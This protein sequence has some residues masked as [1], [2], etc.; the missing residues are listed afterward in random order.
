MVP[1]HDWRLAPNHRNQP[2]LI[3]TFW[4]LTSEKAKANEGVEARDIPSFGR[5]CEDWDFAGAC[6]YHRFEIDN[7]GHYIGDDVSGGKL[8]TN[9]IICY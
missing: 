6:Q 4:R 2:R 8:S 1:I 3:C 5:F 9:S 7:R